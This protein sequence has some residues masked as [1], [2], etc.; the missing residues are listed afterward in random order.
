M[1]PLFL[2][3]GSVRAIIAIA[4]TLTFCVMAYEARVIPEFFIAIL[5]IVIGFYFGK[6]S[7]EK[8]VKP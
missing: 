3:E 7:G 8:E 1:S 6:R 4:L 2:P 5:G